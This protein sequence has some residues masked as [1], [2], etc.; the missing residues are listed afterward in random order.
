MERIPWKDVFYVIDIRCLMR[1]KKNVRSE[2]NRKRSERMKVLS[3]FQ[4]KK[5]EY[6]KV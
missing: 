4:Y 5:I 1:V 2:S 6:D 3:K